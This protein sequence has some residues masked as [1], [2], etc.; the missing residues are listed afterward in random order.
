M[1]QMNQQSVIGSFNATGCCTSEWPNTFP[2]FRPTETLG[3][4]LNFTN[5][6]KVL[7][8]SVL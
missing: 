1:A 7:S 8:I 4:E 2:D 5:H 3:F 6:K